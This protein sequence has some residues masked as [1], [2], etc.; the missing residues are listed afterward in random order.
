MGDTRTGAPTRPG[1]SPD[2]PEIDPSLSG[3]V[4][5]DSVA[6]PDTTP[7]RRARLRRH[8]GCSPARAVSWRRNGR[9][10][11]EGVDVRRPRSDARRRQ[12]LRDPRR[13]AVRDVGSGDDPPVDPRP[14]LLAPAREAG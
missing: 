5:D 12:A 1:R 9:A 6:N 11:E 8:D 10:A 4:P 14:A 13:R 7:C 3:R 2:T